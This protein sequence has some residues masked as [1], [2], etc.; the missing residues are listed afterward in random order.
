MNLRKVLVFIV[1]GMLLLS[2][3]SALRSLLPSLSHFCPNLVLI[4]VVYLALYEGH[5]SAPFLAFFLGLVIDCSTGVVLGPWAG[6]SVAVYLLLSSV[7]QGIFLDN[8]LSIAILAFVTSIVGVF[9]YAALNYKAITVNGV[10]LL[11]MFG[12]SFTNAL[13]A[14]LIFSLME[15]VERRLGLRRVQTRFS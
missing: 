9:A 15:R 1:V 7:S 13:F 11:G 12:E 4:V 14:P 8:F 10:F 5:P 3:Q 6:A 2:I